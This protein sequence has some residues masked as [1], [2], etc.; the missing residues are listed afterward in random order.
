MRGGTSH[1]GSP[2]RDYLRQHV[3]GAPVGRPEIELVL[4]VSRVGASCGTATA[5]GSTNKP[6]ASQTK[7]AKDASNE[8]VSTTTGRRRRS[9]LSS[10]NK[11]RIGRAAM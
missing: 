11:P 5:E 3:L 7:T 6:K 1:A 2:R 8:G 9:L 4:P 10:K